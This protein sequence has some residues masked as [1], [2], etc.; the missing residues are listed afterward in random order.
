MMHARI[1]TY[2]SKDVPIMPDVP[3]ALRLVCTA[4]RVI[5][6][7]PVWSGPLYDSGEAACGK[8]YPYA[9]RF[10]QIHCVSSCCLSQDCFYSTAMVDE[11]M[12]DGG[13]IIS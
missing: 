2:D 8:R 1:K 4:Y 3:V 9:D 10:T 5:R 11:C 7:A 12:R 6:Y 13:G